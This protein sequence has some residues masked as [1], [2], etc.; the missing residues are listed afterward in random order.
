MLT[1]QGNAL[2]LCESTP[3]SNPP[4]FGALYRPTLKAC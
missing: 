3:G 4:P 1:F 2:Y